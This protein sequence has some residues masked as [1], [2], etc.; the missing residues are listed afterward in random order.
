MENAVIIKPNDSVATVIAPV[1]KGALV[2]YPGCA[3]PV[4]AKQDIPIYHKIAIAEVKKGEPVIRY[5]ERIGFATADIAIGEH[6]HIHNVS[7]TQ[8]S[9]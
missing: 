7:S 4:P 1:A 6:V 3:L 8:P 5:G 2:C 9:L